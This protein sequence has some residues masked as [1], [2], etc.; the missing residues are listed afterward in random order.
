MQSAGGRREVTFDAQYLEASGAIYT[1]T[2]TIER[3][4]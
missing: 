1:M 4:K 2:M 3:V